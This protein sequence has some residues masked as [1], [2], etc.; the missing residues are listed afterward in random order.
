MHL[1]LLI[2]ILTFLFYIV[3]LLSYLYVDGV[4]ALFCKEFI[5]P[6]LSLN[7]PIVTLA[8]V[9]SPPRLFAVTLAFVQ[10][11]LSRLFTW[12]HVAR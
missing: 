2:I 11:D 9:P 10:H 8:S 5:P 4:K 12:I 7:L 1:P 3:N 6:L